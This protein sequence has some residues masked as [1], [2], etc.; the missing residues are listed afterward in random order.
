VA[1]LIYA[2]IASLDGCIADDT[3]KFD[4][5]VASDEVHAFI[6]DLE[7]PVGTC[8]YG[9][10]M[11][12]T[13]MGSK[14]VETFEDQ[15]AGLD[16]CRLFLAPIIIGA[17]TRALPDGVRQDL[18]QLEERSFASGFAYLRYRLDR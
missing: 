12:D 16:E 14:H 10:R 2:A 6:N 5:A 13:M 18:E 11:Y 8:L 1:K 17:G 15:R 4:R 7:R 3:G 9:R